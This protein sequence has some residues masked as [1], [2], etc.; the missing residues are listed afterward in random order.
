ML[1][2]RKELFVSH[3]V[4]FLAVAFGLL[5]PSQVI[6]AESSEIPEA[7]QQYKE[8][9]EEDIKAMP[10]VEVS[11]MKS[12]CLSADFMGRLNQS[13]DDLFEDNKAEEEE[14]KSCIEQFNS[15]DFDVLT[16]DPNSLLEGA[17]TGLMDQIDSFACQAVQQTNA[18][19]KTLS[20]NKELPYGLGKIDIQPGYSE[21]GEDVN[22]EQSMSNEEINDSIHESIWGDDVPPPP[23]TTSHNYK[24][25]SDLLG[26]TPENEPK[27]NEAVNKA[28]LKLKDFGFSKKGDQE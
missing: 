3:R 9:S 1:I 6:A 22:F 19:L 20:V 21:E 13:W 27:S 2:T 10:Y 11:A 8:L 15:I 7:C 25:V 28:R 5:I 4:N 12:K 26:N 18:E 14:Q 17:Y 24:K 23:S 16:F